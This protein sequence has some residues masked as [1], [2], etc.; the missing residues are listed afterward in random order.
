MLGL[1]IAIFH[2]IDP[3]KGFFEPAHLH[4]FLDYLDELA[5]VRNR[6]DEWVSCT[7]V[8]VPHNPLS[9]GNIAFTVVSH[10]RHF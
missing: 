3:W 8:S 4:P 5:E 2:L 9:R 10:D 6:L 7:L 1:R